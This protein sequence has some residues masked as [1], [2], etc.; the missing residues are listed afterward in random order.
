MPPTAREIDEQYFLQGISS[1]RA[2]LAEETCPYEYVS[3]TSDARIA[4]IC[5][6]VDWRQG[7]KFGKFVTVQRARVDKSQEIQKA[8]RELVRFER[9]HCEQCEIINRGPMRSGLKHF[10]TQRESSKLAAQIRASKEF[11]LLKDL[12]FEL[13]LPWR[14]DEGPYTFKVFYRILD[15]FSTGGDKEK[16]LRDLVVRYGERHGVQAAW[17]EYVHAE[18]VELL[19]NARVE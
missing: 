9:A 14:A 19:A 17:H 10:S 4:E 5:A 3:D 12:Y 13:Y 2:G 18:S 7:W 15:I 1:A 16:T 8:I 6:P 11:R